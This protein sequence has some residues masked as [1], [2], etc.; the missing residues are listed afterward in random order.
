[1]K[2]RHSTLKRG[3]AGLLA[4]FLCQTAHGGEFDNQYQP[5]QRERCEMYASA[6]IA[7]SNEVC[8][9]IDLFTPKIT[10][11]LSAQTD[12]VKITKASHS[13]W[14]F[15]PVYFQNKITDNGLAIPYFYID[16]IGHE[17][18]IYKNYEIKSVAIGALQ[19]AIIIELREGLGGVH[20]W[21]RQIVFTLSSCESLESHG[22]D[23]FY[24]QNQEL[25]WSPAF[26]NEIYEKRFFAPALCN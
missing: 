24:Y 8:K 17:L 4:A 6:K 15:P 3:A 22:D 12:K 10:A 21:H 9:S 13:D 20:S 11:V 14:A 23:F 2:L 18:E 5:S 16:G 25:G 26:P 1:M 19:G 7:E